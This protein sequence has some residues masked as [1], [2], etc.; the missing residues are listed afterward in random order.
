MDNLKKIFESQ[1]LDDDTKG[2]IREAFDTALEVRTAELK[3]EYEEKL[4][5]AEKKNDADVVSM[6]EEA[7]ADELEE[8]SEEIKHARTLD[9]QYAEKLEEFKESYEANQEEVTKILIQE[10]VA[11]EIDELR[12]DIDRAKKNEFASQLFESFKEFYEAQFDDGSDVSGSVKLKEA[13]DELNL[14]R[15]EKKLNELL[16]GVEGR[17]RKVAQT[18]LEGVELD[19]METRFESIKDILLGENEGDSTETETISESVGD[20]TDGNVVL[21]TE[22]VDASAVEQ[23]ALIRRSLR[24]IR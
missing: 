21:E 7:V 2:V 12:E 14:L 1:I 3:E 6:I 8:L 20:N 19:K 24:A 13:T 5:E 23:N 10:A 18:I 22:E 9:V 17:K 16:E 15:K 11:T 4:V